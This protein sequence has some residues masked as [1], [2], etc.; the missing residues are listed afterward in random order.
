MKF[1]ENIQNR[2]T[3]RHKKCMDFCGNL[4][5]KTI[6]DIGCSFGWFEKFALEQGCKEIIGIEPKE[7]DFYHA[8]KEAPEAIYKEGSVLDIPFVDNYFDLIVM[9]D[10]IEHLPKNTEEKAFKEIK[11]VLGK[12][13]DLIISAPNFNLFSNF[14]DPVWYFGHRHYSKTKLAKLLENQGFKI[15]KIDFGGGFWELFS[16]ILLY[17]FKWLFEQEI[18]FK[19]FFEKKREKEYL[20]KKG[21]VTLFLKAKL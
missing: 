7:R 20:D 21:F 14:F 12:N 2:L 13:G 10:V 4:K 8:K 16:M 15:E 17:I 5:D 1:Q 18:P 19:N 3:G 11:R 6:L 9:F